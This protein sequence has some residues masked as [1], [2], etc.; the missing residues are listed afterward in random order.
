MGAPDIV[1]HPQRIITD[2][3]PALAEQAAAWIANAI[4]GVV[5]ERGRCAIAL[6]GGTTPRAVYCRLARHHTEVPWPSVEVYF[7]DERCVPPHHPESNFQMADQV[8][9]RQVPIPRAQI[10]RMRGE[11]P[12][13]DA[14][15]REYDEILP[16][17]LDVLLLGMGID[18]HTASLFP[19]SPSLDERDR[20]VVAADSPVPPPRRLTITP[21][22]IARARRV[23]VIVAGTEKAPTVERALEGRFDPHAL[24]VQFALGGAWFV[25]RAAA[26][27][28]QSVTA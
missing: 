7:G 19:N 20:R 10:H 2:L 27:L 28:L 25:D 26:A 13:D 15:A 22:V 9:L 14:A 8:L 12:D 21:P 23:A 24:P 5:A 1:K 3:R 11:W 16:D 18:G 17:E 6:S 4:T